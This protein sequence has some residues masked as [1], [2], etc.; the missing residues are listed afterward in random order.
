MSNYAEAK[1]SEENKIAFQNII[2]RYYAKVCK[3]MYLKNGKCYK[4]AKKYRPSE[5]NH[6]VMEKLLKH[7]TNIWACINR[8]VD[9]SVHL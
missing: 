3:E 5:L 1:I 9:G 8:L 4:R 7:E 6:Q 2:S